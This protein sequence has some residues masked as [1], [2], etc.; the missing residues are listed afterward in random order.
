MILKCE[1]C[2]ED[3][4]NFNTDKISISKEITFTCKK[5]GKVFVIENASE[6]KNEGELLL[7]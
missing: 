7:G 1:Q 6:S 4:V 5:C 3:L 2:G